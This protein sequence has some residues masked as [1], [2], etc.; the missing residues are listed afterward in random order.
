MNFIKRAPRYTYN[1]FINFIDNSV[2]DTPP[3]QHFT[4]FIR[5]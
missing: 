3:L 2:C 5:D 4:K 1:F